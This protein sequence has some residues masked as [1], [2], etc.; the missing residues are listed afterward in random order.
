MTLSIRKIEPSDIEQLIEIEKSAA[1]AFLTVPCLAWIADQAVLSQA[2]HL[3]LIETGYS[4]VILDQ[5]QQAFGF[6]YALKREEDF[7][8][9]EV[10]VRA[11]VQKQG[12]GR[13]LLQHVFAFANKEDFKYITLTTFKDVIWNKPFYEKLGFEI[14]QNQGLPKYLQDTLDCEV[15]YGFKREDRC[16]MRKK[17]E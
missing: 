11:D 10:D 8:I 6:L 4:F 17:L 9:V 7:F 13:Q 14:I 2:D 5:R 15:V 16:A 1:Q 12:I 3:E